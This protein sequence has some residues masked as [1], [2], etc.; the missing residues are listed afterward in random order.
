M[1]KK[2]EDG[3]TIKYN[4][5][6]MENIVDPYRP[7]TIATIPKSE[8]KR[9]DYQLDQLHN[10]ALVFTYNTLIQFKDIE[11]RFKEI[12]KRLKRIEKKLRKID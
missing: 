7:S 5:K 3:V 1:D 9:I 12:E 2:V 8:V 11:S 4:S 6:G 10:N